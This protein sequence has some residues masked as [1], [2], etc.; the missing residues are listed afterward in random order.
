MA[1]PVGNKFV[2]LNGSNTQ[3]P[4]QEGK[5]GSL[6]IQVI[7]LRDRWIKGTTTYLPALAKIVRLIEIGLKKSL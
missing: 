6:D 4:F 1:T 3:S 5:L 7:N 2:G